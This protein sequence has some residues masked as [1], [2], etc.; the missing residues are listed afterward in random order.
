[1]VTFNCKEQSG[2]VLTDDQLLLLLLDM[3]SV[4]EILLMGCPKSLISPN[5][6]LPMI[7]SLEHLVFFA[8]A[9]VYLEAPRYF[10]QCLC[11]K[12][13]IV[14]IEETKKPPNRVTMTSRY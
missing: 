14:Y 3:I 10:F 8:L 2:N 12:W 7:I 5:I 1:M 11:F 6:K 9:I 13:S 4:S